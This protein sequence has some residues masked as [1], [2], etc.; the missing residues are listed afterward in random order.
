MSTRRKLT[1]KQTST[2]QRITNRGKDLKLSRVDAI[3]QYLMYGV[4]ARLGQ[5]SEGKKFI[6]KGGVLVANLVD[7]PLRF[8]RDIDLHRTKSPPDPDHVRESFGRVTAIKR[9]D[10]I[11][12]G[13]IRAVHADH[14]ADGYDGVTVYIEARV[15]K[16]SRDVKLDIGFGDAIVPKAEHRDLRPFLQD[17]KLARLRCYAPETVIAEKVETVMKLTPDLQ[18]RMKDL[19]DVVTLS[20]RLSFDGPQ[21]LAA[22]Q[23]T[24]ENRSRK[25]D[26]EALDEMPKELGLDKAQRREWAKMLKEKR[27]RLQVELHEAVAQFLTFVRPLLEAMAEEAECPTRWFEGGPWES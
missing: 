20:N 17:E 8:T 12:F 2:T 24:F 19:F 16:T 18:H 15:G 6:L 27:A 5:S 26:F 13:K 1:A 22:V 25:V 23:A 11:T 4:L 3:E 14:D 7:E 10:G 9:D 21:L